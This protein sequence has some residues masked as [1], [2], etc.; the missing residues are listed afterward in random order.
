MKNSHFFLS[1]LFIS[2]FKMPLVEKTKAR[3][4]RQDGYG[5]FVSFPDSLFTYLTLFGKIIP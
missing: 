3:N 5:L 2:I 1:G 4:R